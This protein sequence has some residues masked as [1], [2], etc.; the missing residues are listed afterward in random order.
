M[1]DPT[2]RPPAT[3]ATSATAAFADPTA[4]VPLDCSAFDP[5]VDR[6][7][8]RRDGD[9]LVVELADPDRRNMMGLA[10]TA[11]WAR[12]MPAIAA[13]TGVRAVLLTG[14]GSAFTSGGDTSWIGADS[15]EPV[16]V[17]RTRMLS[18]YRTWLLIRDLPVPTIAAMNGPA[19]GA[20]AALALACDLRWAGE[21]ASLS[22]PFLQL[23][24]HPGM[25]ST[26]RLTEVAGVAA[27]RDL[28]FTGR[29]IRSSEMRELGMVSR[30]IGDDELIA[31]SLAGAHQVAAAAPTAMRL[32]KA[33]LRDG[34]PRDWRSAME[35]EGLAQAVTLASEDLTEGLDALRE[36]RAPR[37]T[38]R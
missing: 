11:A 3:P 13:D 31:E 10:M 15:H 26:V 27:A 38:G 16:A 2:T 28:L 1:S 14:R 20:G 29:R 33:A 30:V 17:L 25:L 18:Y 12:L 9:V 24:L 19:I 37:F 6:L 23:G 36:K 5:E 4:H 8:V 32:T 34:G 21:S 7:A 22:V 35:W